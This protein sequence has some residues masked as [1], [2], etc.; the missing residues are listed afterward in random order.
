IKGIN[1]EGVVIDRKR[2]TTLKTRV[3]SLNQQVIRLD[4]ESREEISD[5]ISNKISGYVEDISS[6]VDGV[7]ISDYGKGVITYGVLKSISERVN[8]NEVPVVVDP[9]LRNFLDYSDITAFISNQRDVTEV[10]GIRIINETSLRNIGYKLVSSLCCEGVVITQGKEGL[11]VFD[12]EGNLTHIP[13]I[14]RDVF[15]ITGVSDTVTSTFTLA[16]TSGADLVEAAKLANYA[17]WI[18]VGKVGTATVDIDE[19]KEVLNEREID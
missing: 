6:K 3:I 5:P 16:L 12:K 17:G 7:I 1:T 13:A 19:I 11:I 15:D 9:D 2:P 18:V 8:I 4:K 10:L 14:P